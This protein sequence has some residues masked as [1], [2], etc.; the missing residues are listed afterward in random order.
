MGKHVAAVRYF[1][2]DYRRHE[3]DRGLTGYYPVRPTGGFDRPV[4]WRRG[5]STRLSDRD[6]ALLDLEAYRIADLLVTDDQDF[7]LHLR[8]GFDGWRERPVAVPPA[9]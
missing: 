5:P 3:L 2:L 6:A 4:F 7:T 9:A 8:N 1:R